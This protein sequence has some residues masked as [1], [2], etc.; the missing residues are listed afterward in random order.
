[1]IVE[2]LK[3]VLYIDRSN[4]R[5]RHSE[6]MYFALALAH[7]QQARETRRKCHTPSCFVEKGASQ[8]AGSKSSN[9]T[10]TPLSRLPYLC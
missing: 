8:L 1:M 5:R 10:V 7:E 2:P 4:V 6:D 3:N 9:G